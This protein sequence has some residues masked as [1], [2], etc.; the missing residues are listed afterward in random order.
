[1]RSRP[2]SA[3]VCGGAGSGLAI[4][5]SSEAR[6][7]ASG[8]RSSWEALATKRRW[9]ANAPSSRS[10]SPSIVSARSFTSSAGPGTASRACRLSAEIRRVAVVIRRSGLSTRCAVNQPS[11]TETT[12]M[13]ASAATEP[14][15]S[16]C[17]RAWFA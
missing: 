4:A 13:M 7:V 11:T 1:M 3:V 9:A 14:M 5:T 17:H 15:S 16:A 2:A 10:S 12:A 6:M 8:V